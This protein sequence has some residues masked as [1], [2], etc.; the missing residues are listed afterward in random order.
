MLHH[1]DSP[2]NAMQDSNMDFLG[3]DRFA[4]NDIEAKMLHE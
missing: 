3:E 4:Q 2:G 1:E